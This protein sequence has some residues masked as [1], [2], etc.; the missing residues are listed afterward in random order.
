MPKNTFFTRDMLLD[1][2]FEIFR[3]EG[4]EAVSVRRIAAVT[5]SSTAPIYSCFANVEEMRE[6]RAPRHLVPGADIDPE[7]HGDDR[8]A[9]VLV[10]HDP[11]PVGQGVFGDVIGKRHPHTLRDPTRQHVDRRT[12]RP[13]CVC[14]VSAH[15]KC[16]RIAGVRVS[17]TCA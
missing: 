12:T 16:A 17:S 3:E 14:R 13:P 11:Q 10:D 7:V 5:G 9:V 8:H 4:L 15:V 6:A 1:A 2:A